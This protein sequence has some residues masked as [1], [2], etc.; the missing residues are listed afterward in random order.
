MLLK[1]N[2]HK[3]QNKQTKQK[4]NNKL[5]ISVD[6]ELYSAG[7]V[8]SGFILW[9]VFPQPSICQQLVTVVKFVKSKHLPNIIW[10][11]YHSL[12][13][14]VKWLTKFILTQ[15]TEELVKMYSNQNEWTINCTHFA[16]NILC[17]SN[18]NTQFSRN[19]M[20]LTP[21]LRN[22]WSKRGCY[23]CILLNFVIIIIILMQLISLL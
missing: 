18:T 1:T 11:G 20:A 13:V 12:N 2:K 23:K 8:L 3:K 9:W 14:H 4:Q 15:S 19:Q 22:Y 6:D 5:I 7:R 21:P 10:K 17:T 16:E